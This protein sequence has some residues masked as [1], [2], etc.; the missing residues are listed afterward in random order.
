VGEQITTDKSDPCG[1]D[2]A[3]QKSH[4]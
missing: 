3:V 4:T 2:F 1:E